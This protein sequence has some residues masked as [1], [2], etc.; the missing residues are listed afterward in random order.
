LLKGD[1][2]PRLSALGLNRYILEEIS[3][4]SGLI[5][6][7]SFILAF[8]LKRLSKNVESRS[9]QRCRKLKEL[10]ITEDTIEKIHSFDLTLFE[11]DSTPK[12]QFT[13]LHSKNKTYLRAWDKQD[14]TFAGF[15][16]ISGLK[17]QTWRDL[18]AGKIRRAIDISDKGFVNRFEMATGLYIHDIV[19]GCDGGNLSSPRGVIVYAL[20]KEAQS[21]LVSNRNILDLFCRPVTK[22]GIRLARKWGFE[23]IKPTS[24]GPAIWTISSA[25]F[26][27]RINNRYRCQNS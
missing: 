25:E 21:I 20:L 9:N 2:G 22:D 27:K 17:K 23:E 19:G 11:D 10:P 6:I 14:G 7:V 3:L 24:P 26:L 5:A 8:L 1:P 12:V 16:L 4:I 15:Y 13:F 18:H